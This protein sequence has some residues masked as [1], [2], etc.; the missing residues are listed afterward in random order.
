MTVRPVMLA[1]GIPPL[2]AFVLGFFGLVQVNEAGVVGASAVVTASAGPE[3]GSNQRVVNALERVART[4]GATIARV[5]ADRAAPTTRR[6]VLVTDAP[7]SRG[8]AWLRDGAPDF[9]RSMTTEVRPMSVLDEYDPTGS[10]DVFG[11]ERA[12][13]ATMAALADVGY[14]VTSERLPW[15][16]RVGV[17]DG[18]TSTT[19]LV[20]ALT[21]GCVILCLTGTIGSPRRSAIRRLHGWSA[22]RV[23]L[24]ELSDARAGVL[25]VAVGTPVVTAGLWVYNGLTS[26]TTLAAAVAALWAALL[27]PVLASHVIGTLLAYRRPMVG[28]LRGARPGGLVAVVAQ[29]A[30]VPAL[31]LLVAAVFELTGA[32]AVARA[33]TAERDLRAAGDTV[34]LW[35]TPDPR[36]IGTQRY[37]DRIGE[38][39]GHAI[40]HRDALLSATVEVSTGRGRTTVPAVVVDPGYLRLRDVRAADGTRVT[41]GDR[42]SVWLPA[43]SDLARGPLVRSLSEWELRD[44]PAP[45]RQ[46]IAGGRLAPQELYSYPG[47]SVARSWFDDAVLV[48]V[49][50]PAEAFSADQLGSWL[51]TGDVVFTNRAAA[52]RSIRPSGLASEFSAV[53]AV[54]QVAAEQ[55]RRAATAVIIGGA[56][57]ASSSVVG[58]VLALLATTAHRRRHGRALFARFAS[59]APFL[60]VDTGLLAMEAALL[61]MATVVA[62]NRWWDQRPDGTGRNSVLD[63]V[64]QSA[65]TAGA[66]AALALVA[67][68]AAS[69]VALAVTAR[70]VTR[71]RGNG[72]R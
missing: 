43:D 3:T 34:Q 58:L 1:Y 60:R 22:G 35:V 10:Y 42:V 8:E 53:V 38:F 39:A 32:V 31:L 7:T 61:M 4:E 19:G 59:G 6:A 21:L 36:P 33:G 44:A 71:T 2:L 9:S 65:G 63:P 11:D 28:S 64:A 48:V 25:V 24:A 54:G 51:S 12:R 27:L 23:L 72:S 66:L 17:T 67:L 15:L 37:W 30:R 50:E 69:V 14:E 40:A 57:V 18:V 29:A 26:A 5:V 49:P 70:N 46:D 41:A 13:K 20:G 68:S 56:T 52:E 45:V 62:I 55:A 47:D 16:Q